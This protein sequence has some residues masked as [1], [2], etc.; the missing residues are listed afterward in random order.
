MNTLTYKQTNKGKSH[1]WHDHFLFIWFNSDDFINYCQFLNIFS[2]S[3]LYQYIFKYLTLE[4]NWWNIFGWFNT[5]H[6][7]SI[8]ERFRRRWRKIKPFFSVVVNTK[9]VEGLRKKPLVEYWRDLALMQYK[10]KKDVN[11]GMYYSMWH[12]HT[13]LRL[14]SFLFPSCVRIV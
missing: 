5:L 1:L 8:I 6:S 14:E 12:T 3:L 10:R 13:S 11:D 7:K 2:S 4:L 9:N